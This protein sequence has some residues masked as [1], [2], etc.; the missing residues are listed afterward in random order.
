M[1]S[2]S[3]Y[4][5]TTATSL[6]LGRQFRH[7]DELPRKILKNTMVLSSDRLEP[8][9]VSKDVSRSTSQRRRV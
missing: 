5:G 2:L 8:R 6:N 7:Q 9:K 3:D 4:Y 1:E